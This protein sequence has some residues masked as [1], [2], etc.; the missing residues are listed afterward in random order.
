[1]FYTHNFIEYIYKKI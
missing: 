1:M